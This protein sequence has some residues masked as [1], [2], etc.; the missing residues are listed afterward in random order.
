L[1]YCSQSVCRP[2]IKRVEKLCA[3]GKEM[4]SRTKSNHYKGALS[5]LPPNK[6]IKSM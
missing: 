5:C 2:M 1:R 4:T 6:W 3:S